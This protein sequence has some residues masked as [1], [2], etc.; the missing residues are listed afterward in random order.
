MTSQA[1]PNLVAAVAAFVILHR[2]ISGSELRAVLVRRLSEHVFRVLFALAELGCLIW[3]GAAYVGLHDPAYLRPLWP[4]PEPARYVAFL[5]QPAALLLIVAGLATPNPGSV[6]QE[7]VALRPNAVQGVLRITRHPFLWGVALLA[8]A[9][10]AVTP[11]VRDLLVFGAI[12]FVALAGTV[13]IDAKRRCALGENWQAFAAQTSNIPFLAIALGRQHLRL[14]EIGWSVLLISV[15]LTGAAI[16]AQASW[17]SARIE[18]VQDGRVGEP[19]SEIGFRIVKVGPADG[20]TVVV[21]VPGWFGGAGS[22]ILFGQRLAQL[23]PGTQVWIFE[24]REQALAD[25]S[26]ARAPSVAA[27]VDYYAGAEHR[28]PLS[29]ASTLVQG[30]GLSTALDDL[31]Q[32]VFAASDHGRHSVYLGG[33]S[34]GATTALSY[35]AWDFDGQAGYKDTAGL[36]VIDGGVHDAFAGGG[37]VFRVTPE[38]ARARLQQIHDGKLFDNTLSLALG[39]GD[40]PET[41]GVLY[42]LAGA[43]ARRASDELSPLATLLPQ[44]WRPP[45]PLSNRAM[46]GWLV[47]AH[48]PLPDLQIHAGR[49]PANAAATAWLDDGPASLDDVARAYGN[50]EVAMWEWFWPNRLSLDLEAIDPFAPSDVTDLLGLRLTHGR[51]INVPLYVFATSSTHGSVTASAK[52]FVAHS[53]VT[54]A[55]Y[56]GD[57]AMTHID[58]LF[59]RS[60][61]NRCLQTLSAFLRERASR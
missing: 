24:R 41:A 57:D 58:P 3:L 8:L 40:R 50:P 46:L 51:E 44:R 33:H 36:I 19:R 9:Y 49:L 28:Q 54:D 18:I 29:N 34:W 15:F 43:A 47:T 16:L 1:L 52:W 55:I 32:V 56:D 37:Q 13:S 59:A 31:R 38:T 6:G 26:G 35:A 30:W 42:L 7:K 12:A 60:E 45:G 25:L 39:L 14:R 20:R 2:A 22:L 27:M 53:S 4:A 5:L 10:L 17:A 61:A 11:T 23:T 48:A 21:L